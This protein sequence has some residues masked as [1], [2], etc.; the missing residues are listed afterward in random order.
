MLHTDTLDYTLSAVLAPPKEEQGTFQTAGNLIAATGVD[1]LNTM[2]RSVTFGAYEDTTEDWLQSMGAD[3][4]LSTYYDH[5]EGIQTASLI[6]GALV[7]GIAAIKA[8]NYARNGMKGANW[9]STAGRTENL[10]GAEKLFAN[11]FAETTQYKAARNLVYRNAIANGMVDNVAAEFAMIATMSAHPMME[12][13]MENPISSIGFSLAIGGVL[14]SGIDT[15]VARK[16]LTTMEGT[17]VGQANKQV[18]DNVAVEL[19]NQGASITNYLVHSS[20]IVRLEGILKTNDLNA[21]TRENAASMVEKLKAEWQTMLGEAVTD[22]ELMKNT[23][24][25][26][27]ILTNPGVVGAESMKYYKPLKVSAV[28]QTVNRFVDG[29]LDAA[30]KPRLKDRGKNKAPKV[31]GAV[32]DSKRNAFVDL[33][34]A[35]ILTGAADFTTPE[36][37]LEAGTKASKTMHALRPG[38]MENMLSASPGDQE[39]DFLTRVIGY[40]KMDSKK[41][42][43][44]L[45]DEEDYASQVALVMAMDERR[46][47]L[48]TQAGVGTPEEGLRAALELEELDKAVIRV[49]EGGDLSH[50]LTKGYMAEHSIPAN[51]IPQLH[52]ITA[53]ISAGTHSSIKRIQF[54]SEM[55]QSFARL[56]SKWEAGSASAI[57]SIDPV[58]LQEVAVGTA[59]SSTIHA[60]EYV[61]RQ[62]D[63]ALRPGGSNALVK[64]ADWVDPM[65]KGDHG[66][67]LR[68][69]LKEKADDNGNIFL[70]R[71]LSVPKTN[72]HSALESYTTSYAAARN[73]GKY[74]EAYQ[75][76]VDDVVAYIGGLPV[77]GVDPSGRNIKSE[78][79]VL[80]KTASRTTLKDLTQRA[81]KVNQETGDFLLPGV[82]ET[83]LDELS[84]S[85]PAMMAERVRSLLIKNNKA[86]GNKLNIEE[87][88]TRTGLTEKGVMSALTMRGS[89]PKLEFTIQSMMDGETNLAS[90]AQKMADPSRRL[91]Q[92]TPQ[93]SLTNYAKFASNVKSKADKETLDTFNDE[94]VRHELSISQS[95]ISKEVEA[96]GAKIELAVVEEAAGMINSNMLQGRF[97]KSADFY[98][99][100]LGEVGQIATHMANK[101]TN[102]GN[103]ITKQHIL[104]LRDLAAAVTRNRADTVLANTAYEV[105]KTL[106]SRKGKIRFNHDEGT[107]QQ[108]NKKAEVEGSDKLG[109]WEDAKWQGKEFVIPESA[110]D[111][112]DLFQ[113]FGD[114]ADKIYQATK[115]RNKI[116]GLKTNDAG[117]HIPNYDPTGKITFFVHTKRNGVLT[118]EVIW[119]KTK[120]EVSRKQF[121]VE[122]AAKEGG[123]HVE[124]ITPQD[125]NYKKIQAGSDAQ[126]MREADATKLK[127]GNTATPFISDSSESLGGIIEG[128]QQGLLSEV[129]RTMS[130]TQHKLTSMLDN[131]TALESRYLSA[132]ALDKVEKE[133]LQGALAPSVVKAMIQ[134]KPV[135]KEFQGWSAVDNGMEWLTGEGL[136]LVNKIV[137]PLSGAKGAI[138]G[139]KK[140]VEAWAELGAELERKGYPDP[141]AVYNDNGFAAFEVART[142]HPTENARRAVS[143]ANGL[144]ATFALRLAELGQPLVNALSLPIMSYSAMA[145]QYDGVFMGQV[146]GAVKPNPLAIMYDG[147][148]MLNDPDYAALTGRGQPDGVGLWAKGGYVDPIVSEATDMIRMAH[149]REPGFIPKIEKFL[150]AV[151]PAQRDANGKVIPGQRKWGWLTSASDASEKLTRM[152]SMAMGT[153]L[154]VRLYGF[155]LATEAGQKAS[156]IFASDFTNRAIGNYTSSQRPVMFQGT[157]GAALGLFQT[158]MLT[159][160]QNMYRHLE[161]KDY[162][163]IG[164]TAAL[165]GGV[166]GMN[167]LPGFDLLSTYIGENF[168][169]NHKD[170]RTGTYAAIPNQTAANAVLYGLPASIGALWGESDGFGMSSRGELS[171]RFVGITDDNLAA[172]SMITDAASA[173]WRV[174]DSMA[175]RPENALAAMAEGLTLQSV[176]RPVA[177]MTE[178]ITGTALN[179]AENV[180][181]T[182][183]D[184]WTPAGIASRIFAMRSADEVRQRQA[185]HLNSHYNA[186]DSERRQV[187]MNRMKTALRE[188][189]LTDDVLAEASQE[190]LKT[191]S[192]QGFRNAMNNAIGGI[193]QGVDYSA[194]KAMSA[195]SP[196]WRMVNDI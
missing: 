168:S 41:L 127:K 58:T 164:I 74:V 130:L 185:L 178:L 10:A 148:R 6:G 145:H 150:D 53:D 101:V 48:K 34:S 87:I 49:Y 24:L 166:F 76:H 128:L 169:D 71:G 155:D 4:V 175:D 179:Q 139:N 165:Q 62:L 91:V 94:Y 78:F 112:R 12:D 28:G 95:T 196:L 159:F 141:W 189:N 187:A 86:T 45:I 36:K 19:A 25:L 176:S 142:L 160:A 66:K 43:M 83:T 60:F 144:A 54:E 195:E 167:G 68:A 108:W 104:P 177:R 3:E 16:A 21:V 157:F 80:V 26:D 97:F 77:S 174:L 44:Q 105:Y 69:A 192:P 11:G 106:D 171:P 56:A 61:R 115:T 122:Q 55:P 103:Q 116:T 172:L 84:A 182:S 180:V 100:K 72:G 151:G 27:K 99:R 147:M 124:I 92:L 42:G 2:V 183:D 138:L 126:V 184:V 117:Y 137:A 194:A 79:E 23:E 1:I 57:I 190:Y 136:N 156:M 125:R 170:L 143:A 75:I 188:G 114:V 47:L 140:A 161:V 35:E 5:K 173:T 111:V 15:I 52:E 13:Y 22:S 149:L 64:R 59:G 146:K 135:T 9:F 134:G 32:F 31:L 29:I 63:A 17:V 118:R 33:E 67:K 154:G 89:N 39:K 109:A 119:G 96:L 46:A 14:S 30:G 50:T 82:R 40:S 70:Y 102:Y 90:A 113:G 153:Q 65:L 123:Y 186:V 132:Q 181:N 191:G 18:F 163:A 51:M 93:Q 98:M 38:Y 107:F 37:L 73:L 81:A 152:A 133:R 120:E 110:K 121:L 8:V 129:S 88:A 193:E 131:M 85:L 158:Y 7:P 20:S 162:K